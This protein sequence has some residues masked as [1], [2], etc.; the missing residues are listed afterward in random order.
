MSKIESNPKGMS[1][2]YINDACAALVDCSQPYTHWFDSRYE[3]TADS[4]RRNGVEP[5][6]GNR[7]KQNMTAA[8]RRLQ[9]N[10]G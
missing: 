8:Y 2:D 6:L 4:F 10:P 3:E 7:W 1:I 9:N 5:I